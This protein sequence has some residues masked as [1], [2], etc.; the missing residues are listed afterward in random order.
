MTFQ[1]LNQSVV[2]KLVVNENYLGRS[3]NQKKLFQFLLESYFGANNVKLTEK[4]IAFEVFE[5]DDSFNP[6]TDSIVRTEIYRLRKN[7]EKFNCKGREIHGFTITIPPQSLNLS[8]KEV[9]TLSLSSQVS[10]NKSVVFLSLAFAA[11]ILL[12]FDFSPANKENLRA[13]RPVAAEQTFLPTLNI[14]VSTATGA[15]AE[16]EI[17]I[18]DELKYILEQRVF[19][20]FTKGENAEYTFVVEVNDVPGT[21]LLEAYLHIA[22]ASGDQVWNTRRQFNKNEGVD[23]AKNIADF[24]FLEAQ[25]LEEKFLIFHASNPL[26]SEGRRRLVQCYLDASNYTVKEVPNFLGPNPLECLD[27]GLSSSAK[28][29]ALIHLMRADIYVG[30][31]LKNINIDVVDPWKLAERE[32][33]LAQKYNFNSLRYYELKVSLEMLRDPFDR[34]KLERT[35]IAF[36]DEYPENIFSR[37]S[38]SV[39]YAQN[40]G[41]WDKALPLADEISEEDNTKFKTI[42][43]VYTFYHISQ[44]NW[45]KARASFD[46][47]P[48]QTATL[49][50]VLETAINCNISPSLPNDNVRNRLIKQNIETPKKFSNY[51]YS[52]NMHSS[53]ANKI[54]DEHVLGKCVLLSN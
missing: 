3:H 6:Q 47:I 25:K 21:S 31:L 27:A 7:L 44:S 52:R 51:V 38:R 5:K 40:F 53:I 34:E 49:L 11:I 23:F 22:S 4:Q 48:K 10:R 19:L 24:A 36:E 32:L 54:L 46:L 28:D 2:L 43:I 37:Y 13:L 39:T 14:N 42:Y 9:E 41:E 12:I 16:D 15:Y 1:K 50:T 45:K 20:K 18:Y 17:K 8:I 26:L 33:A 35:L 29:K 30:I